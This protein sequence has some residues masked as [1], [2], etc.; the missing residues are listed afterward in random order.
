[1]TS[2]FVIRDLFQLPGDVTVLACEGVDDNAPPAFNGLFARIHNNEG[3][4]QVI[5]LNGERRMLNKSRPISFR[6][7]ETL[8][9]VQLSVEEAQSGAWFMSIDD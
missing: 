5:R 9:K 8:E 7:A 6:A 3:S 1:M 4:R 2:K